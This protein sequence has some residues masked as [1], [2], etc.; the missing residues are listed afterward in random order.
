MRKPIF[1][2][3]WIEFSANGGFALKFCPWGYFDERPY[4][5]IQLPFLF[6]L[7]LHLP[8]KT[9]VD[10]CEHPA[11]GI[12]WYSQAL[13]F[14]C[15]R[16]VYA[17]HMPWSWD[18]YKR[19]EQIDGYSSNEKHWVEVP[20]RAPYGKIATKETHDYTYVL[21]SGEI[22]KRKAEIYVN[23][24]EWRMRGFKWLPWPNKTQVSIDVRFD[25][26]VGEETRSWKGGCVGCGH[27]MM[28]GDTPLQTLRRMENE[29]KF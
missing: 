26:E 6:D 8:F 28:A 13:W 29:R 19:W 15:W 22:Q 20:R 25:D 3:K 23:R 5:N 21:K 18:F 17:W 16:K 27:T 7:F 14:C 11:L 9:G 2:N 1:R 12:Y 10:E 4:I 24:M